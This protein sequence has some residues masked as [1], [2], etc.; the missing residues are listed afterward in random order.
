MH[1]KRRNAISTFFSIASIRRLEPII[2]ENMDKLMTRIAMAGET[3]E[4]LRMHFVLKACASDIITKYAFG[5]SFHFL[6]EDDFAT[7]Y[8]EATDV[9][10][11]F[12]HA[13][14]HFPIVGTLLATASPWAIKTFIPGLT[15]MW[16][17]R[18]V[19]SAAAQYEVETRHQTSSWL[20]FV[21]TVQMWLEQFERIKASPN[22]DRFKDT[23]FEGI[24]GSKLPDEEKTNA[25]LAHEAQLVVFAGQV[26]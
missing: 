8:M 21:A 3:G 19:C 17:K 9:F 2:Q 15:G 13:M 11:L 22:P 12:N 6:D 7:P 16:D 26:L 1:R 25:R 23:I 5:N 10:H 24:L 18:G 20:T 14:C 4:V